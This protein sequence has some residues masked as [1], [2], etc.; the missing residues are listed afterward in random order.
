MYTKYGGVSIIISFSL[1]Q[2]SFLFIKKRDLFQLLTCY[3]CWPAERV[4]ASSVPTA[5]RPDLL[6]LCF[7]IDYYCTQQPNTRRNVTRSLRKQK[8]LGPIFCFQIKG[9]KCKQCICQI[10]RNLEPRLYDT[11]FVFFQPL[12]GSH[13]Q[14]RLG[15]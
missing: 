12:L 15:E 6:H 14:T 11:P 13:D 2:F 1:D 5:K 10:L 7:Y 3:N 4:C 8:L 9:C